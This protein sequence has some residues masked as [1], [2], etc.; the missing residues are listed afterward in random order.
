[1]SR[2]GR[3]WWQSDE[4]VEA[5][6]EPDP[7][8]VET[9]RIDRGPWCCKACG[10]DWP[11]A[12]RGCSCGGTIWTYPHL[13]RPDDTCGGCRG[14]GEVVTMKEP[15]ALCPFCKGTGKRTAANR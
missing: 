2:A 8:R 11:E 6:Y 9:Q 13:Y 15:G 4:Y 3:A 5:E 7:P 1:M 10:A 14:T 12:Q